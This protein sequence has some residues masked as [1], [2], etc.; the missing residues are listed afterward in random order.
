MPRLARWAAVVVL[1]ALGPAVRGQ[2]PAKPVAKVAFGSCADQTKPCPV[3][4]R[5]AEQK[6]DLLVLLGDNVYS[7]IE[8]GKLVPA[9][10]AKIARC[11]RELA[12][13]PAFKALRQQCPVL[14]TWDD[15]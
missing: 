3:W 5:I 8:D 4:T 15:H 10:P 1:V 7:D 11:Y 14:A 12:A 6:P 9:D 13:I 2:N